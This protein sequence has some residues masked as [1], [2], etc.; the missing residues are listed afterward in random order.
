MLKNLNKIG[1][2][3]QAAVN[4]EY[5]LLAVLIAVALVGAVT[6]FGQQVLALYEMFPFD[7]FD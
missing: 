4:T 3:E 7:L 5:A 1:S 6:L 2:D